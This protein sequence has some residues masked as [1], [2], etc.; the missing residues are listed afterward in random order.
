[1]NDLTVPIKPPSICHTV[2]LNQ[3][4]LQLASAFRKRTATY[5][6]YRLMT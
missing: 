4:E 6:F 3:R 1:L 5:K 2:Q